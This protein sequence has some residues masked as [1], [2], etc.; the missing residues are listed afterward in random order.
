MAN[1]RTMGL[2]V[3]KRPKSEEVRRN[4]DG[5]H[6]GRGE[7]SMIVYPKLYKSRFQWMLFELINIRNRVVYFLEICPSSPR[8]CVG[9][10]PRT[11]RTKHHRIEECLLHFVRKCSTTGRYC[12][13]LACR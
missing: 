2:K 4:K 6:P 3:K 10:L 9:R 1:A 12:S 13:I 8:H 7:I 5:T 11:K